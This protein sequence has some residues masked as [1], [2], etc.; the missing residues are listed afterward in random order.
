MG[1][2]IQLKNLCQKNEIEFLEIDVDK[3]SMLDR[4]ERLASK[5]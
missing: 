3:E 4:I 2:N 1:M 5:Y